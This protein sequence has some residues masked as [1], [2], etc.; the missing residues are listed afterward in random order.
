MIAFRK[1]RRK[2]YSFNWSLNKKKW[3]WKK[4]R[5]KTCCN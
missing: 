3:I 2:S 5:I 1:K 4:K